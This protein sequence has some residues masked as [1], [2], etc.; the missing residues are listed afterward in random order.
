MPALSL[1]AIS[2]QR[3]VG[4]PDRAAEIERLRE[5]T[6]TIGF[7]YLV[8]HG[9]PE[10]LQRRLFAVAKKFFAQPAEVKEEISN[11]A[12]PQYRGYAAVGDERTQGQ[13]T[14]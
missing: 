12:S 6:H 9:V 11:I 14:R 5:V 4:G 2:L 7:F 8:D 3:L 10:D 1:P 13:V